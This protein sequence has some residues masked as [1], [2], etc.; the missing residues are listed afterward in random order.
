MIFKRHLPFLPICFFNISDCLAIAILDRNR[1]SLI[2]V[3]AQILITNKYIL[4]GRKSWKG[5]KVKSRIHAFFT[6]LI[7]YK[8][9]IANH[10]RRGDRICL[11]CA[12]RDRLSRRQVAPKDELPNNVA[13]NP[14]WSQTNHEHWLALEVFEVSCL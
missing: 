11:Y 6:A 8:I 13:S 12:V 3:Q 5:T 14:I 10:H 1:V 9:K 7:H 2:F 4:I